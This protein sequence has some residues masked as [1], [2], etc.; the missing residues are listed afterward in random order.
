MKIITYWSTFLFFFISSITCHAIENCDE[1]ESVFDEQK[2]SFSGVVVEIDY[3]DNKDDEDVDESWMIVVDDGQAALVN[4]ESKKCLMRYVH[5]SAKPPSNCI[6]GSKIKIQGHLEYDSFF[7]D[8][9]A[10][11]KVKS[12]SCK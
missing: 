1:N 8:L 6:K 9:G 7:V 10:S 3:T 2:V 5:L 12:V 11:L 4:G